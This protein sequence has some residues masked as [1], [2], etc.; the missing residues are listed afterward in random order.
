QEKNHYH[1]LD[2]KTHLQEV[3]QKNS[4][5]PISYRIIDETGPD[6]NKVF[7]AEVCH[8]DTILG[9]GKGRSK[10]EAE[11]SAANDA[12]KHMKV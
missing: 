8:G 1:T 9:K 4:K 2:C 5:M 12:L 7:V 6:H 10:K 11:Q 3:I